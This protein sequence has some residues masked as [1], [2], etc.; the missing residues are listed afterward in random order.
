[1]LT[2]LLPL[3][4]KV[5]APVNKLFCVNVIGLLPAVKLDVPGTVNTPV[6]VIA[7]VELIVKLFPTV[8]VPNTKAVLL[9]KLTLLTPLLFNDTAP[10][11]KLFC[12]NAMALAPAL[13]LEV[14]ATVKIPVWVIAPPVLMIKF[15]PILEVVKLSA[16]LVV[17]LTS[18]APLLFKLTS[19]VN[20]LLCVKVIGFAPAVK[21]EVPG[22]VNT[23]VCVIAPPA[24]ATKFPPLVKVVAAKDIAALLNVNVKF[25]RLVI[26][27][28][29]GIAA[30]AFELFRE[31]S[32]IFVKV[33]ANTGA[34]VPKLFVWVSNISE[35]TAVT[36]NVLA[37]PVAVNAPVCVIDPP[38]VT[39]RVLP[40]VDVPNTK[41][42]P[43][44]ILTAF[45][46]LLLSDTA[47]VKALLCVK[48]I[49]LVP[50]L[51]L[52]VP[53]TVNTP[54]CVIAPPELTVKF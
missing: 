28:K 47:P 22:T 12:V 43:L 19:P 27:V 10:V 33:P 13:K 16:P 36:L 20:E 54:V 38:A 18:L 26:P 32:R 3:L 30:P 41:A 1:M 24:V 7:P 21:V 50:A 25:R 51:K 2:L 40:I 6:C 35:A 52:D 8:E 39:L 37:P 49:A 53:G 4:L 5:T 44:V 17:S 23:P 29:L 11:N 42:D 46:P 15:C 31:I 48:V 9:V 45:T 34:E 14:P